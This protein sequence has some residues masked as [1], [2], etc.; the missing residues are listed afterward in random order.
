MK[1]SRKRLLI[2]SVAMLL[3]A[4]LALGTATFA[5]F[6][7]NTRS[8]ADEINVKTSKVSTLV[9]S[10]HDKTN[11]VTHLQYGIT[12]AKVMYPASSPNGTNWFYGSTTAENRATG[13]IDLSTLRTVDTA[14]V[15]GY[16]TFN[17][18]YVFAEELNIKNDGAATVKNISI[19]ISGLQG[20]Y[21][22]VALVPVGD[23]SDDTVK[24]IDGS[25]KQSI[26]QASSEQYF[27]INSDGTAVETG[28][29]NKITTSASTTVNVPNL[30]PNEKA[31]Y[32]LFVWFEGQDSDCIDAN[33][34][35]EMPNLYFDVAGTPE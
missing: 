20:D 7:Q 17:R 9:L 24:T 6:T 8:Y 11:W 22:C 25:F 1:K 27:A 10:K 13:A 34:G 12:T 19:T 18:D 14:A 21:A 3:V 15:S 16:T 23:S 4:M 26:H 2:S 32:K 29:T 35:Q 5:W 33:S 28:D 31:Y 30:A